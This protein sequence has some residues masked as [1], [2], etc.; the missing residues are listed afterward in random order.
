LHH[1]V[2]FMDIQLRSIRRIPSKQSGTLMIVALM[3][4]VTR[5]C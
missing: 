2:V 5:D 3:A 4:D 1:C